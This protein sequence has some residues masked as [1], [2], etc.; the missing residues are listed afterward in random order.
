[1]LGQAEGRPDDVDEPGHDRED[2]DDRR[3]VARA[4]H[5]ADGHADPDQRRGVQPEHERSDDRR[6]DLAARR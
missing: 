1:M 4:E 2:R 6:R 3:R 5:A